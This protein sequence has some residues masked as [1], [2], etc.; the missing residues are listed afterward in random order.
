MENAKPATVA[1]GPSVDEEFELMMEYLQSD[2]FML[3]GDVEGASGPFSESCQA[4]DTMQVS[5][6]MC[7]TYA[8]LQPDQIQAE[9]T[10]LLS[11]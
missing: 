6:A 3:S 10:F 5:E 9:H 7:Q 1:T 2:G 11:N 4:S 8:V